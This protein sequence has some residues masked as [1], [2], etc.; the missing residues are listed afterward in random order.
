[1][2]WAGTFNAPPVIRNEQSIFFP[3]DTIRNLKDP[4]F[5]DAIATL[6]MYDPASFLEHAPTMFYAE[7]EDIAHKVPV[8]F[9]H[10]IGGSSRSFEPMVAQLDR[11]HYKPWFF[12]YPSGGDLDQ[13]ATLFY[14][15]FLS[16]EVIPLADT[17]VIVVA[18]SMG[19][20][21]VRE[22]INRYQGRPSENRLALFATIATPFA[23][24]PAA[25]IGEKRGM[26]VLP[27]WRDLN[28]QSKFINDL[29]RKP[30]PD[31]VN[32]QLFYAYENA[33]ALKI[34]SNSDGVVPLSS[35]L[36]SR[37]QQQSQEQFGFKSGHVDI[38]NNSELIAQ[39]LGKIQQ[40][41]GVFPESHI[42]IL[43]EG[44]F[45]I[46][47]HNSYSPLTQYIIRYAGK[48]F[49]L[50]ANNKFAPIN[51]HHE[52]FIKAIRGEV[53]ASTTLEKEFKTFMIEHRHTIEV[54]LKTH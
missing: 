33:T 39:L 13:L 44:G 26:I 19:G 25:A 27:A 10:G 23:G 38:L 28:P 11:S 52:R 18:H 42:Q 47:P 17:P 54:F 50:L 41:K 34:G 3:A 2:E 46:D 9:V 1:M 43:L 6:G 48:Y 20:L 31:F 32:H 30:L 53:P 45:A 21:V 51:S 5:D 12:Y 7:E 16:G 29:F 37:A 8:I 49:V 15:I 24:H 35:Q 40:V 22:A 14:K 4:I 36:D